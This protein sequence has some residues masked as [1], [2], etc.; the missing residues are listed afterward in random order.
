MADKKVLVIVPF[1]VDEEHLAMRRQ[2]HEAMNFG[3]DIDFHYRS[4]K[5]SGRNLISPY[6]WPIGETA[7]LEAGLSAQEESYDAVC[8][9]TTGDTGVSGLRAILDIPV[10]GAARA[11]FLTAMLLGDKFSVIAMWD[12]WN[13]AY[14]RTIN[15]LGIAHK[16]ASVRDIGAT[17]DNRALMSGKEEAFPLLEEAARLCIEEDGADVL[18]L[19]STT[20]HQAHAYLKDRLD[21]PVIDPGPLTY[22]IIEALLG[23]GLS[24]SRQAYK[25]PVTR[26]DDIIHGMVAAGAAS[27]GDS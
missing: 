11:S 5:V 12:R 2:Q 25:G 17:P 10:I 24:H 21:V 9:D 6:E 13:D 23:L 3:P 4:V 1:P 8:V 7:V 18:C 26:V 27:S 20:M 15:E 16:F 22:K 19:G 14:A